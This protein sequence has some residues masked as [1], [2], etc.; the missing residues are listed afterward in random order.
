VFGGGVDD[1]RFDRQV[2]VQKIRLLRR[3]RV[4]AADARRR[5]KHEFRLLAAEKFVYRALIE[6]IELFAR[7]HHQ[8]LE[9]APA[10]F[11]DDRRPDE[12]AMTGN[13]D[14]AARVH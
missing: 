11:S 14:A 3:V 5:E 1:V 7:S 9:T 6:K 12:T 13:E 10:Q 8:I 2:L 4:D